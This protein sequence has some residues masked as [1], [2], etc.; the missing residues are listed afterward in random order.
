[1]WKRALKTRKQHSD[2]LI[3]GQF[4]I[5]DFDNLNT[6]TYVKRYEGKRVLVALNF[7]DGEQSLNI[8][9]PMRGAKLNLLLSNVDRLGEKL[10]GWEARAYLVE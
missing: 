2:V 5:V 6:F 3:H 7:S 1:M 4:E 8:P 10:S 9:P